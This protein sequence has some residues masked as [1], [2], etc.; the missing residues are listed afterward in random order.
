M[1]DCK[2]R[3]WDVNQHGS[4]KC[5]LECEARVQKQVHGSG[6]GYRLQKRKPKSQVWTQLYLEWTQMRIDW[7]NV[8]EFEKTEKKNLNVLKK[9]VSLS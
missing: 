5:V 7:E 2:V 9:I 4:L 1:S 8:D 3:F 6:R